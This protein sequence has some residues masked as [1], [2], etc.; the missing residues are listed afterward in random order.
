MPGFHN[1]QHVAGF[2][3]GQR[4]QQPF[5]QNQQA[6]FLVLLANLLVDSL[7]PGDRHFIEQVR[8]A[9]VF[10][11]VEIA[12]GGNAKGAG[13]IGFAGA[14]RA[15]DD[16]V[17]FFGDI[18]ATC[19]PGDL[20]PVEFAVGMVFNVFNCSAALL[21]ISLADQFRRLSRKLSHKPEK[22]I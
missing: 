13:E 21:Q 14:G 5:V 18:S 17:V 15:E 7:A 19:Q 16:D 4:Q 1:L 10:D 20:S 8:Q 3:V 2:A 6:D 9:D 22:R 12:A 11:C